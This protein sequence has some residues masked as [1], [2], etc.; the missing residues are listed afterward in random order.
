MACA[1]AKLADLRNAMPRMSLTP[2][3]ALLSILLG[4]AQLLG[5]LLLIF[6][7]I[8]F[9]YWDVSKYQNAKYV[10]KGGG[11]D[12]E[13]ML[14]CNLSYTKYQSYFFYLE[15]IYH[16]FICMYVYIKQMKTSIFHFVYK[17]C[18]HLQVK[19]Q[20][21]T[22]VFADNYALIIRIKMND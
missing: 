17:N 22:E 14:K 3:L 7:L 16:R 11:N 8:R 9:D 15:V 19:I 10:W 12:L 1:Q 6:T 4:S 20:S 18:L 2:L 5:I 13:L 21:Y